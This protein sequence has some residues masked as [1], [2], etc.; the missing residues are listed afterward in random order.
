[1]KL[2]PLPTVPSPPE[3]HWRQFRV[4]CVPYLAF[5]VVLILA[6]WLWGQNLAN[7]LLQGTAEGPEADVASPKAGRIAALNVVLYQ[8]VKAGDV[9]AIVDPLNPTILSNTLA[10]ARAEAE[11]IRTDS[12]FRI[13]DK[14][15][16]AQ[17]Q[18]T[19]MRQQTDLLAARS[20]LLYATNEFQ[21]V[22]NLFT[23]PTNLASQVEYDWALRD[24]QQAEELVKGYTLA[25]AATEKSL[26]QLDPDRPDSP[27]LKAALAVAEAR[28]QLVA[29]E[30][31][32]L[33][34]TA[35]ISGRVIK[36]SAPAGATVAAAAPIVTIASPE[37]NRII[38]FIGLPLRIEP[39]VG[40]E[41]EIRSRGQRRV[42]GRSRIT[43]VGP[44]IELFNAPMRLRT[45][46]AAQ[47]RGLPIA[48]PPP[49]HMG[50]RPGELVDLNLVLDGRSD[51]AA[52]G[53]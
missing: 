18:N 13:A 16:Y 27:S 29:A 38:G 30:F 2:D 40:M 24:Y 5:G 10:L 7:P 32:P 48:M 17:F 51:S 9:I 22:S 1:M 15:R 33:A 49:P 36:I 34:L 6:F 21:R 28:F 41:V 19:W 53:R 39:Q 8:E 12:G 47:E 31:Q 35:P 14:V 20:Q 23:A 52:R 46:E 50:L 37:V 25:L 26:T 42:V 11:Q 45:M 44:R 4:K 3:H 43:Y